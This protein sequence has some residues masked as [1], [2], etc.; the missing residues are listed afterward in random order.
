[1]VK[2]YRNAEVGYPKGFFKRPVSGLDMTLDCS[3]YAEVQ[4]GDSEAG[5]DQDEEVWK[6]Q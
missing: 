3:K 6:P 2:V 1:M 4:E 5:P